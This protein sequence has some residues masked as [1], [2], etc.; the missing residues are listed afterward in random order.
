MPMKAIVIGL[1]IAARFGLVLGL[2]IWVGMAALSA[3][4]LRSGIVQPERYVRRQLLIA[5]ALVVIGMAA[6]VA[7]DRAWPPLDQLVGVGALVCLRALSFR[8]SSRWL[9]VAESAGAAY[10]LWSVS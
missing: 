10:I 8:V 4:L 2:G 3:R 9:L 5:A 7:L 6:R 1:V